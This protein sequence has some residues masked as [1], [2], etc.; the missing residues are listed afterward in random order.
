MT[1]LATLPYLAAVLGVLLDNRK[2]AARDD[3]MGLAEVAVDLL[4][5]EGDLL[6]ESFQF[7]GQTEAA[8]DAWSCHC[9]P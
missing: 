5:R 7:F 1:Y 4:Q 3:A 2:N 9:R 6:L 8:A